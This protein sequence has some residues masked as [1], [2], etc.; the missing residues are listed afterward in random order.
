MMRLTFLIYHLPRISRAQDR[1]VEEAQMQ[2]IE[3][4]E[5]GIYTLHNQREFVV[6]ASGDRGGYW[7]SSLGA[8]QRYGMPEYRTPYCQLNFIER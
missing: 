5:R 6:C 4:R 3:L 8:W 2:A 7:L 1:Q